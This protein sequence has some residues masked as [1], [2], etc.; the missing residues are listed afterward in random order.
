MRVESALRHSLDEAAPGADHPRCGHVPGARERAAALVGTQQQQLHVADGGHARAV[1]APWVLRA[2][3]CS[4]VSTAG[5]GPDSRR[6]PQVAQHVGAI[7][8]EGSDAEAR[9]DGRLAIA[10]A[11]EMQVAARV[12]S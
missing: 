6:L 1:A 4:P 12:Q 7:V 11:A 2:A 10:R 5:A 3:A 9:A 8:H